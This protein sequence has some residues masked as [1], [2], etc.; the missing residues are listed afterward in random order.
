MSQS[1]LSEVFTKIRLVLEAG[2]T[3]VV[4]FDLDFT[5][6]D[7]TPRSLG[8]LQHLAEVHS[9]D[10][11]EL[12]SGLSPVPADLPYDHSAILEQVGISPDHHIFPELISQFGDLFFSSRFLHLDQPIDGAVEYI[13]KVM[14]AGATIVYL[15]GRDR[16]GMYDGTVASLKTHG[17]P[18][19]HLRS[20][21][22]MK[23]DTVTRDWN[24][25]R[26]AR[27][28]IASYGTL[29][30]FF[31]NEPPNA[32]EFLEAFPKAIIVLVDTKCAPG[33]PQLRRGVKKIKDFTMP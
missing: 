10:L 19:A 31:D 29:V 16:L 20:H 4:V 18:L 7:N 26:K 28:D 6:F 2:H 11:P 1:C 5:L 33:H 24:F 30:A 25:K 21:L 14:K 17:F 23:P 9:E 3:P 13:G 27:R 22:Y 12:S 15:T 8:I 32:N